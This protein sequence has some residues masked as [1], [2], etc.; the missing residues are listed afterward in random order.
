MQR[1]ILVHPHIKQLTI[2]HTH[3]HTIRRRVELSHIKMA[4]GTSLEEARKEMNYPLI[5]VSAFDS[6]W[7]GGTDC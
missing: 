3:L 6:N 5:R 4:G 2:T 7:P 1:V